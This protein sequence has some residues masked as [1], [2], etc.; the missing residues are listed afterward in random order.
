MKVINPVGRKLETGA[1]FDMTPDGC[2][3]SSGSHDTSARIP[4]T[5]CLCQCDH[6]SVNDA[7]NGQVGEIQRFRVT[8]A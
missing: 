6:G 4:C 7:A 2:F 5:Q 1:D 8:T 3:C